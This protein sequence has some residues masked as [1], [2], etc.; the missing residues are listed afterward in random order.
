MSLLEYSVSRLR[1]SV[2]VRLVVYK[3]DGIGVVDCSRVHRAIQP[4]LELAYTDQDVFIEVASPGVDRLIKDASEFVVF[5]GRGVRCYRTDTSDW[6]AGVVA[7]ASEKRLVLRDSS[8]LTEIPYG[9]IA[10]AKLD[11]SQEV[12]P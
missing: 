4:R 6:S 9:V 7:E 1:G 5:I 3:K 2:Q 12:E 10:K 11:Y 8:G